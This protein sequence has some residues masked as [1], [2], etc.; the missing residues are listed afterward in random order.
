MNESDGKTNQALVSRIFD[1]Q[2]LI[3]TALEKGAGVDMLERL[4]AL[5]KDV[6]AVSARE[7][8]NEA[9]ADFQKRCPSIMKT[10]RAEIPTRSGGKFTYSYAPLDEILSTVQPIMGE[11]GLSIAWRGQTLSP[12]AVTIDCRVSHKLGHFEDSGPVTIPVVQDGRMNPGQAV[13]SAL[14][15]AKR[16]SALGILG[17]APEDDDD[18]A[19]DEHDGENDETTALVAEIMELWR[20][21]KWTRAQVKE[22]LRTRGLSESL[23]DARISWATVDLAAVTELRDQMKKEAGR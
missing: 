5:A 12:S 13:G 17:I 18:M 9:M 11:L 6:R 3:Q 22:C 19:A 21:M 14:T 10:R 2:A 8:W 15:Y 4:V 7:A 16:Y 1:P 23:A 20:D